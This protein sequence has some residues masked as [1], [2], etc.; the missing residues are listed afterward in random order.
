LLDTAATIGVRET[1]RIV[2][3]YTLTVEDLASGREFDDAI[4][5]CG[6]PI[7]VHSPDGSR[8]GTDGQPDVANVYQIPYR[9]LV[10]TG[11]EQLLVA[12]RCVSASHEALGAI[13]VMP[14]SFAMG[15]A[16]GTAA[17]L[18]V[19]EGVPPRRV[20]VRWLQE[21]LVK[22]GVYLGDRV[23]R[24]VRARGGRE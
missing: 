1:R 24:E 9:C 22:D 16:A 17:A 12:G 7:D 10:P 3:E 13:R 8:G 15:Q 4:A 14:P 11:A 18:S 23:T 2:G 6:Y 19:A 21:T 20:P 5:L